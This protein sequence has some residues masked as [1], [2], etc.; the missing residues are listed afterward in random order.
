[1]LTI[2]TEIRG[3]VSVNKQSVRQQLWCP[4]CT[5]APCALGSSGP[6]GREQPSGTSSG[7]KWWHLHWVLVCPTDDLDKLTLWTRAF[8]EVKFTLCGNQKQLKLQQ[9]MK[10]N[11]GEIHCGNQK[12]LITMHCSNVWAWIH[13]SPALVLA[14]TQQTRGQ[15]GT[16][17]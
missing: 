5:R 15:L 12:Q 7:N 2:W 8:F 14:T 13:G 11:W 10:W 4:T 17:G 9:W 3:S 6:K 1:M 16:S